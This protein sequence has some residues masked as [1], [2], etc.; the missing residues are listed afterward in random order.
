MNEMPLESET[1]P[2]FLGDVDMRYVDRPDPLYAGMHMHAE[3]RVFMLQWR[4][5]IPG[6]H[7]HFPIGECGEAPGPS[8][9][10]S[11]WQDVRCER[12]PS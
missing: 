5:G 3:P 8:V 10:W 12:E 6:P 2:K 9:I 7:Q 1:V 4:R 11:P